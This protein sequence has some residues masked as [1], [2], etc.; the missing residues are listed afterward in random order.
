MRATSVPM[1]SADRL[2]ALARTRLS[3]EVGT[4]FKEAPERVAMVYP[5]PYSV[6][7]SSLGYQQIYRTI[8]AQPGRA[9]ER[10]FL[11]DDVEAHHRVPLFCYESGRPVSDFQVVALSVAYELELAGVVKVLD[12]AGMPPL[13][14]E[15]GDADPFVLCGGPLTFSNPLPL[16]PF[17][18]AVL[19]GEADETVHQALD[20]IFGCATKDEAKRA[21]ARAI[22]SCF[23]P[24][25]HGDDMP[26]NAK[27]A[28]ALLPAY[29]A[30]RTPH[31]ELSNMFLLE[32]ERGCHRQCQYCVM[33]R[34]TNGGMRI[35]P[36]E[37]IL[38]LIPDDAKKVGLVGA[39]VSDHPKIAEIV[40]TLAD[41]GRQV[42]LSSLRPD[43]LN[44]RF[45]A[46]LKRA[47]YRTLTT[48]SDGSSQRLR[49][50]MQRKARE[51]HIEKAAMLAREH[52][53]KRLKLYMM[54]GLPDET[55]DDIDEL[56]EFGIG[57]SKNRPGQPRHRPLRQQA[58]HA[59]GRTALRRH[60][61]RGE[62]AGPAAP[63]V[64]GPRRSQGHQR[65]L[66]VGRVGARPRRSPRGPRPARRRARG[67]LLPRLPAR[68]RRPPRRAP[69]PPARR[70]RLNVSRGSA[71]LED[72][73]P[74][75]ASAV[76]VRWN[77]ARGARSERWCARRRSRP[78]SF[79]RAPRRA[80]A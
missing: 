61:G 52:K 31:T 35:V 33:R 59:A 45:V 74:L 13:A 18:D 3:D 9:A 26:D 23:V 42:G 73:R 19:M 50:Q 4:L 34:S 63:R 17:A 48:A 49:D 71:R 80:R 39:A 76:D 46:A 40:E 66:G 53:M 69:A 38:E 78:R 77:G 54:V 20:I 58:E 43:R 47:G 70:R 6:A 41:Q 8:N 60:Q 67:R 56:I 27:C 51:R 22:P 44:D 28:D 7:M 10:A 30:I 1:A 11:P 14:E 12:L 24:S 21:L 62:A 36:K 16:A 29:A 72:L 64:Q 79:L 55:D 57:L 75:G 37:R 15:R 25:L 2:R 68:V 5:S 65:A 32:A